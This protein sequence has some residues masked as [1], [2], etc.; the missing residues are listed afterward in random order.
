[1]LRLIR[2]NF[3]VGLRNKSNIIWNLIFPF[4][5]MLIYV[6]ALNRVAAGDYGVQTVEIGIIQQEQEKKKGF[7]LDFRSFLEA[8]ETEEAEIRDGAF[9]RANVANNE[10]QP[11]LIL[12]RFADSKEDAETW[13]KKG[14]T[15]ATVYLGDEIR[16]E[17]ID[18][19]QL[20]K[21]MILREVLG[22]YERVNDN[23]DQ[24]KLATKEGRLS[25]RDFI[26]I[27]K[28]FDVRQARTIDRSGRKESVP[29]DRAYYY[30]VM[31]YICFFPVNAGVQAVLNTEADRSLTGLRN[32][33]SAQSKRRRFLSWISGH[34]CASDDYMYIL[35]FCPHHAPGLEAQPGWTCS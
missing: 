1:M 9:V 22:S 8:F 31:A 24:I 6:V 27:E 7:E 13:H 21:P 5:F 33:V 20:I 32:T 15:Y 29:P 35:C 3:L 10:E 30:A 28:R 16:F 17:V 26:G 18:N 23:I 25:L 11:P 19:S 14:Q 12:Y 2:Y 4:A 34:R